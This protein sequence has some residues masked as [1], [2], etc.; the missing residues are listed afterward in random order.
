MRRHQVT[1]PALDL[2]ALDA[3]D[4]NVTIMVEFARSRGVAL[5]PHAKSHKSVDIARRLIKSGAV[6]ACCATIGEAEAMAT[7]GVSGILVTSPLTASHMLDRLGTLLLR[8]ADVMMVADDVGNVAQLAEMAAARC[9]RYDW[10]VHSITK[11]PRSALRYRPQLPS[12]SHRNPTPSM[13]LQAFNSLSSYLVQ[14][15]GQASRALDVASNL[16]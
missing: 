14:K 3:L 11:R 6:G 8:G 10:R 5:R 4:A 7:G 15:I 13:E 1:T 9:Q 12:P 16:S 2:D